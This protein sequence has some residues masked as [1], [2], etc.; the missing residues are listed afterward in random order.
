MGD[1][2]KAL[3]ALRDAVAIDGDG[4]GLLNDP[5]LA[6]LQNDPEFRRLTSI[7]P[8]EKSEGAP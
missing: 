1:R 3:V 6:P 5:L 2:H 8:S 4:K 7:H